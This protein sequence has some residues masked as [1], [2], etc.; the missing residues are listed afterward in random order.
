MIKGKYTLLAAAIL[1]STV[2]AAC[3]PSGSA[4]A[5]PM[6]R[7][8]ASGASGTQAQPSGNEK[9]AAEQ[10]PYHKIT[11]EEAKKMMDEGNVTVVD[12][13]RADEYA[14]GHIPGSILIPLESIGDEQPV[15]LPDPDAVLL[16]HCR[17]G[18]R[19]KQASD[20]LVKLGY[21]HVYDF[22]GIADWSYETVAAD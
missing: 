1:C 11:A 22:G 20:Q 18:I 4:K 12:V 14:T 16:V 15:E 7:E 17:T 21:K 13:R 19:S 10:D 9:A 6:T 3:S 5:E 8:E 2:L